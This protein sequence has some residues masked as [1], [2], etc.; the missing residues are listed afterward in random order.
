MGADSDPARQ[1]CWR[2]GRGRLGSQALSR[3]AAAPP[4][5]PDSQT[6]DAPGL[7]HA[8]PSIPG[9]DSKTRPGLQLE[10]L[11]SSTPATAPPRRLGARTRHQAQAREGDR[12]GRAGLERAHDS[13]FRPRE[14]APEPQ[15]EARSALVGAEH[16]TRCVSRAAE[17]RGLQLGPQSPPGEEETHCVQVPGGAD[18]ASRA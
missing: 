12:A 4:D 3:E 6:I 11:V 1:A 7:L 17:Q 15:V 9:F 18:S 2:P 5:A 13:S 16:P 14:G 8:G 10:Q